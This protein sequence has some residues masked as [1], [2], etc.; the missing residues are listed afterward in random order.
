MAG[1]LHGKPRPSRWADAVLT[2]SSVVLVS[3][4]PFK[5]TFGFT[6][7][8][9]PAKLCVLGTIILETQLVREIRSLD[10]RT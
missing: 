4:L 6:N 3:L 5:W 9:V 7:Y 8:A 1:V 2:V 10:L